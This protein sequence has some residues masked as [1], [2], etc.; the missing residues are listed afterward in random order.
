[1]DIHLVLLTGPKYIY[2][3]Q[4]K[5]YLEL[6]NI[7]KHFSRTFPKDSTYSHYK[8]MIEHTLTHTFKRYSLRTDYMLG[9]VISF[10]IHRLEWP[11]KLFLKE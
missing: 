11:L 9:T 7:K 8:Y 6:K 1:M 5:D 2:L 4:S 10:R 3:I